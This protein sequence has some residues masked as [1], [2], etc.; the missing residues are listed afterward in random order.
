MTDIL[1]TTNITKR[2][3]DQR[4]VDRVNLTVRRG[5]VYGLVGQNGAGKTTLI[6]MVAGLTEASE[7]Q[8]EL[9]GHATPNNL[10]QARRRIGSIIETPAFYPNMNARDNL[11]CYRLQYGI[12]ERDC[13]QRMLALVGLQ[14]TG[15]KRFRDFSLGMKQRLGLALALLNNPDLLLLDEPINGL[16]P[17]GIVEIRELIKRLS[18]Q[19]ITIL[20]SSHILTE[21]A[22]VAT[23]YGFIHRGRLLL[24]IGEK[25]LAEQCRRS[26][27]ITVSDTAKALTVLEGILNPEDLKVIN[28]TELRVYGYSGDPAELMGSLYGAGIA[29]SGLTQIGDSL[30]DF[31][32]DLIGGHNA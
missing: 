30:E 17:T 22:Q 7:G 19:G 6:R 28:A 9:M 15:K 14:D 12:P 8:I 16:D 27:H 24:E 13:V 20:I 21:M 31:F 25:E 29:V 1:K 18:A 10:V 2:Y 3:G 23:C 11:E 32:T 4:A 26:L 5:E